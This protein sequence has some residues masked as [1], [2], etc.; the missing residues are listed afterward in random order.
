MGR[1]FYF[2]ALAEVFIV[3]SIEALRGNFNLLRDLCEVE[4]WEVC[5]I[6]ESANAL[7][8]D[9]CISDG[10]RKRNSYYAFGCG[11]VISPRTFHTLS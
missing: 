7:S 2:S 6:E 9:L 10:K 4:F 11:F 1:L 8:S 5:F 3:F